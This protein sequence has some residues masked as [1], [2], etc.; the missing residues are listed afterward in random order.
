LS[1]SR[2]SRAAGE[3]AA[4]GGG[5]RADADLQLAIDAFIGTALARATLLDR[6]LDDDFAER[7]VDLLVTG[8]APRAGPPVTS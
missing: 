2:R 4:P 8:L 6:P 7:L 1:P 3:R 5:I